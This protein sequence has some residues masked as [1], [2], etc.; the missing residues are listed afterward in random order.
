[1]KEYWKYIENDASAMKRFFEAVVSSVEGMKYSEPDAY[2]KAYLTIHE[3]IF[4]KHFNETLAKKAV[5]EMEN[6]DGTD[7]EYW[8]LQQ[9][10]QVMNS[11]NLK[12]NPYDFYYVMNMLHSDFSKILGDDVKTYTEMTRAYIDDPDAED[13]KVYCIWK[14]RFM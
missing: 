14:A 12:Y 9:T 5:A 6:V 11:N 8:T 2:W 13:S 10:T 4:G 1:M 7:G 3:S